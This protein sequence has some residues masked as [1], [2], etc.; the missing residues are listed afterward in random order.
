[1]GFYRVLF[2]SSMIQT[3]R[4]GFIVK[5]KD[6]GFSCAQSFNPVSIRGSENILMIQVHQKF[7]SNN[8]TL[9]SLKLPC[10]FNLNIFMNTLK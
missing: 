5:L 10:I 7:V 4:I 9:N 6:F 2:Y 8:L 1:M 3:I